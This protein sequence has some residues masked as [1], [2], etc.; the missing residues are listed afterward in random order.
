MGGAAAATF[1]LEAMLGDVAD[2]GML[3]L[4]PEDGLGYGAESLLLPLKGVVFV[5]PGQARERSMR[6]LLVTPGGNKEGLLKSK[7]SSSAASRFTKASINWFC[8]L[9]SRE[10]SL[11]VPVPVPHAGV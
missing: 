4:L 5:G 8:S 10:M 9:V 1:A 2:V 3:A 6:A 7:S 11:Y